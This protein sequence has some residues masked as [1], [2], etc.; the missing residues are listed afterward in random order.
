VLKISGVHARY[1]NIAALQGVDLEIG[2]GEIVALIGANGAGK[3]TLLMT[4]CGRPRAVRGEIRFEGRDITRLS[5]FEIVRLRI[6]QVPE[7]RRIFPRMTVLENLKIGASIADPAWFEEDLA[8]AFALFPIPGQ[9]QR[10][11]GGTLPAG[12]SRCWPSPGAD[13]P[14]GRLPLLDE[15]SSAWRPDRQAD[16]TPPGNQPARAGDRSSSRTPITHPARQSRLR[17]ADWPN[18]SRRHRGASG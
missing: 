11:R 9:R 16:S 12:S 2:A 6:A 4:L 13:E 8:R 10:Q 3:S 1:G 18:H 17:H 14:A 5:T 7:G 15:P